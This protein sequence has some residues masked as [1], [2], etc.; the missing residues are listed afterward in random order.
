MLVFLTKLS[1]MEFSVR[2]FGCA[3]S[4]LFFASCFAVVSVY[5]DLL[6]LLEFL[7]V[8]YLFLLFSNYTVMIFLMMLL[9]MLLSMLKIPLSACNVIHLMICYNSLR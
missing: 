9:V 1:L 6:L 7:K 2:V 3:Y 4:F 8:P 5:K